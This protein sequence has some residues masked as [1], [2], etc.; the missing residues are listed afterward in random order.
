MD[1][2]IKFEP[3]GRSGVVATGTY[4]FDAARR[5]GVGIEAECER[6]GACDSCKVTILSGKN[7]LSE[8]TKAEL[9]RLDAEQIIKGERLSCQTKI[10]SAGEITVMAEKKKEPEKSEEEKAKEAEAK[11]V[12][13]FRKEFREMPLEKKIATL[14]DLE[15]AALSETVSYVVN[16]PYKIVDKIFDVLAEFGLKMDRAD[17]ERQRPAEH[18]EEEKAEENGASGKK[19]KS[20][21]KAADEKTEEKSADE[22]TADEGGAAEKKDE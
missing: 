9:E 7:L 3:D 8:P 19:K 1:V 6:Q 14:V 4:L 12:E 22:K 20:S 11:R 18:K 21:K 15:A 2:E 17:K 16:S 13:D 10:I 5:L